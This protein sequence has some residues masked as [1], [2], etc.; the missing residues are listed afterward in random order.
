MTLLVAFSGTLLVFTTI[1]WFVALTMAT[2]ILFFDG[3]EI[4]ALLPRA[5]EHGEPRES[6]I[7]RGA[8]SGT[9]LGLGLAVLVALALVVATLGS[10][11][12]WIMG[13]TAAGVALALA[14]RRSGV[15]GS[16]RR[17]AVG[18]FCAF[19][20]A[21]VSLVLLPRSDPPMD[22]RAA[23]ERPLRRWL[24]HVHSMQWWRM[25]SPGA[26]RTAVDL[27]VDVTLA[28]GTSTAIGS[29]LPGIDDGPLGLGRDK[30][31]KIA[32]RLAGRDGAQW[33]TKWHGRY[34][35]RRWALDHGGVP[36]A[37]VSLFA[38]LTPT[39]PPDAYASSDLSEV[40]VEAAAARS[41]NPIWQATCAYEIHGQLDP[42]VATR[43]GLAIEEAHRPWVKPRASTWAD[44]RARGDVPDL[45]WPFVALGV[46]MLVAA[47]GRGPSGL[48]RRT[49]AP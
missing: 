20:V 38:V 39:G 23:I 40:R 2:A 49:S 10:A 21:A 33:Y 3:K 34:V 15:D 18:W 13:L 48:R 24:D 16:S 9:P 46:P 32:R 29:G 37:E 25:F 47:W 14:A 1:G 8:L 41:R 11:V 28:D 6:A 17:F 19:H 42:E 4:G 5:R 30:A 31:E 44:A 36:P 26:P 7:D 27:E 43:Y 35:C 22:A 45:P 12:T